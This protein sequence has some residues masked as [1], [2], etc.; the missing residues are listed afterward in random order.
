MNNFQFSLPEVFSQEFFI[1][2][3]KSWVFICELLPWMSL[4]GIHSSLKNLD[5]SYA[6]QFL[7]HVSSILLSSFFSFSFFSFFHVLCSARFCII[8]SCLFSLLFFPFSLHVYILVFAMITTQRKPGNQLCINYNCTCE[9][10]KLSYC[11]W[12]SKSKILL[13]HCGVLSSSRHHFLISML[14]IQLCGQLFCDLT[15]LLWFSLYILNSLYNF[16]V[17]NWSNSCMYVRY[18]KQI[19][20]LDAQVNSL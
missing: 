13:G 9:L 20:E 8:L 10:N 17:L 19:I 14:W 16:V 1:L 18:N 11:N 3:C 7:F 12:A 6:T 5:N 2:K 15:W 4:L